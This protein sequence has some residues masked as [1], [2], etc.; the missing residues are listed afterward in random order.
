MKPKAL[1]I[2]FDLKRLPSLPLPPPTQQVS[3]RGGGGGGHVGHSPDPRAGERTGPG[4]EEG[5]CSSDLQCAEE[6]ASD[7]PDTQQ[8][9]DPGLNDPGLNDPGL[10]DPGLNDPGLN[11]PSLCFFTDRAFLK[12]F[13]SICGFALNQ[14]PGYFYPRQQQ[15]SGR[16]GGD[17]DSLTLSG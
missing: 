1:H 2:W 11:D 8:H 4:L 13:H 6:P 7:W 10:N 17:R 5:G 3:R 15:Q 14:G 16:E 9:N 12:D